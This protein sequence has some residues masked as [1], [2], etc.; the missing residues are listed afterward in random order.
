VG[1]DDGAIRVLGDLVSF[2]DASKTKHPLAIEVLLLKSPSGDLIQPPKKRK[3]PIEVLRFSPNGAYLAAGCTDGYIDL[4]SVDKDDGGAVKGFEL[5]GVCKGHAGSISQVD[6]DVE[7]KHLQSNTWTDELKFWNIPACSEHTRSADLRDAAWA[8]FTCRLAWHV[9]ASVPTGN[10]SSLKSICRQRAPDGKPPTVFA[11]GFSNGRIKLMPFPAPEADFQGHAVTSSSRAINHVCYTRDDAFLV[12]AGGPEPTLEIYRHFEAVDIPSEDS[13]IRDILHAQR[14]VSFQE[15]QV[16]ADDPEMHTVKPYLGAV[17]PPSTE[18]FIKPLSAFPNYSFLLDHVQSFRGHDSRHNVFFSASGSIVFMACGMVVVQDESLAE[19][20]SDA[21]EVPRQRH[22]L[23]HP[24]ELSCIA[25]HPQGRLV[26][27]AD[28][29]R[30]PVVLV[31]DSEDFDERTRKFKVLG[32]LAG[33]LIQGKM[34]ADRVGI[35]HVCFGG[36]KGQWIFAIG[37]SEGCPMSWYKRGQDGWHTSQL[38]ATVPTIVTKLGKFLALACNPVDQTVVTCGVKHLK[39]WTVHERTQSMAAE[40]AFYGTE[41]A[42]TMCCVD[43]LRLGDSN[44]RTVTGSIDGCLC[45]WKKEQLIGLVKDA[46]TLPTLKSVRGVS[47]FDLAFD[48]GSALLYSGGRDGMLR[49]WAVDDSIFFSDDATLKAKGESGPLRSSACAGCGFYQS[50]PAP[51]GIRTCPNCNLREL[52]ELA[53]SL[54]C[55]RSVS[56]RG[57]EVVLGTSR[58]ELVRVVPDSFAQHTQ[59]SASLPKEMRVAVASHGHRAVSAVEFHPVHATTFFTAGDDC[60]VRMWD[61]ET[62]RLELCIWVAEAL[63]SAD[64]EEAAPDA[65]ATALHVSRDGS[66][67]AVGFSNGHLA[68]LAMEAGDRKKLRLCSA[69]EMG[70]E[71]GFLRRGRGISCLAF[72]GGLGA[73]A[74]LAVGS[75]EGAIYIFHCEQRGGSGVGC[76]LRATARGHSGSVLTIDWGSDGASM[77]STSREYELLFWRLEEVPAGM[78][79]QAL[80]HP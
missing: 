9:L 76:V 68:L 40:R 54:A 1:Q 48:M 49:I 79:Q 15:Q 10:E 18:P 61:A 34:L 8:T 75:V 3:V 5:V 66:L 65:A 72:G 42:R 36:D 16:A 63:G 33:T 12:V 38:V 53:G 28:R 60:I 71:C 70:G 56:V 29:G 44:S 26:A 58:G 55:I 52:D 2:V 14:A 73:G 39:F 23:E 77:Q 43:F 22:F 17:F 45:I 67:V 47:I 24:G 35:S 80:H 50:V 6:F 69:A 46:H 32:R 74:A 31:W 37:L 78:P 57:Q 64:G 51:G 4:F 11:A 41:H 30:S 7:S 25:L 27:S 59:V 13:D 19:G 20:S 21:R 62:K